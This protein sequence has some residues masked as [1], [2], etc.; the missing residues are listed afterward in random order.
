[1]F[2]IYKRPL[3]EVLRKTLFFWGTF[4][5]IIV[6]RMRFASLKSSVLDKAVFYDM[7]FWEYTASFSKILLWYFRQVV[8][9]DGV[10]LI[11]DFG[12]WILDRNYWKLML[13][14]LVGC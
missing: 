1:M 5:V 9:F 3:R 4:L 11:W 7:S 2:F 12:I 13:S 10:V 8:L 14:Q 6:A